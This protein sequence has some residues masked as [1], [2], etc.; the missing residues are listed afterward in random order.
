MGNASLSNLFCSFLRLG[1]VAFGGPAMI[2]YIRKLALSHKW[3]DEHCF[4]DGV[5]FCQTI[6]GATA[7]Q[8]AAYVGLKAN[9]IAGAA[10]SFIGFGLP[11]FTLMM[12]LSALYARFHTLPAAISAFGGLHAV[13]IAIMASATV[14][15]GKTA[16]KNRRNAA[17]AAFCVALFGA[18]VNPIIVIAA[19]GFAGFVMLRNQGKSGTEI[20]ISPQACYFKLIMVIL[21]VF[22]LGLAM[23]FFVA[24]P[25]FDIGFLMARID[26]LAFGGGFASVPLMFH[27]VVQ[28]HSWMDRPTFL[29]GIVL[30][31]ITPGPIVITATYIG[32]L[33][34]GLIGGIIATLSVFLPSFL[35]VVALAPY[36]D[37]LRAKPAFRKII[38]GILSSFVGFLAVVTLR[39][40]V[41][42]HWNLTL[43]LLSILSFIALIFKVDILSVVAVGILVSI[44]FI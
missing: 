16:I 13:V 38:A 27:Y 23:L 6:P 41:G 2:P 15:F 40:A 39:F 10:A 3:V 42:I 28:V 5:A 21:L 19:A 37:R 26:L 14:L 22:G 31:Q 9:G 34:A 43:S 1:T 25:L 11:A 30:G 24:R 32:Y 18:A 20:H 36:F 8:T 7:M 35:M 17:I 4:D 44:I 29:D 33:L 12:I